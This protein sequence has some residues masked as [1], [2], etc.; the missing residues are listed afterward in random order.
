MI[1]DLKMLIYLDQKKFRWSS[2][3]IVK[4]LCIKVLTIY[5]DNFLPLIAPTDDIL[6]ILVWPIYVHFKTL[7]LI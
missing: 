1:S 4:K 6:Y 5:H 7:R 3:K 2:L